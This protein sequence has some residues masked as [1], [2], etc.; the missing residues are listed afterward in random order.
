MAQ[1]QSLFHFTT[2]QTQQG[3]QEAMTVVRTVADVPTVS[4]DEAQTTLTLQGPAANVAMAQW[5][6]T[7]LDTPGNEGAVLEFDSPT[8]GDVVRVN[9]LANIAPGQ[10]MQEALTVLRTVADI[11]KVFNFTSRRAL[12]VRAKP[13]D[14]AFAE[15]ILDQLNLPPGQKM[16]AAP[17]VYPGV[18]GHGMVA[19]VHYLTNAT[20]APAMQWL[21][22][23]ERMVGR[24]AKIFNYTGLHALILRAPEADMAR[25][26]WLIQELDIPPGQQIAG[27]QVYR[28]PGADDVTRIFFLPN[29]SPQGMNAA[30]TAIKS[31]AKIRDACSMTIPSAVVV[32]GTADQ[33]EAAVEIMAQ[34]NGLAMLDV[35]PAR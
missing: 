8:T 5:I 26:E 10:P 1:G 13:A 4:A 12:V 17:R 27:A 11:A 33:I 9:F 21:L 35:P 28:T 16:D 25:A 34:R 19:S 15:W 3:I 30:L 20:S 29:G 22:T 24:V 31:E 2:A 23:S 18:T 32:R 14:M 7:Q 6:L